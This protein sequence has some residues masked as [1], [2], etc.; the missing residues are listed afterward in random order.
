MPPAVAVWA[1]T[2]TVILG[3]PGRAALI[4]VCLAAVMVLLREPGQ[5]LLVGGLGACA[6]VITWLRCEAAEAARASGL[7]TGTIEG[8][9]RG[10]PRD[11]GDGTWLVQLS[12]EGY[13]VALPVFAG[14]EAEEITAGTLVEVT[15]RAAEATRP[16]VGTVTLSGEVTPLA[17]PRGFAAFAADV[18]E[19]FGTAVEWA[20]GDHAQGLIP[21]MVLGDVSLQTDAEQLA[22]VNTGLSHLSAVSGA[23]CM[24]VAAAALVAARLCRAGLRVQLLAAA[25]ALLVYAGLVGPEPS[26]LRASVTGMVGCVAII[27]STRAEPIHALCLSV[28]GLVFVDSDLAVNYG[29]ALSVAA[30][31]GIVAISPLFY[32]ALA[33]TGWP[34]IFLRALSVALAADLA[35]APIIAGMVGQVSLVAVVANV[36]VSPVTGAVTVLGMLAAIAAQFSPYAAAPLLWIIQPM[37]GWVRTVAE[38]GAGLPGST[39]AAT[40]AVVAVCY[41]WILAGFV[42]KRP[43]LTLACTTTLMLVLVTGVSGLPGGEGGGKVDVDTLTAH[44]VNDEEDVE[45][46]PAGTGIVVVL[47]GGEPHTR[48]V[49]TRDGVPVLYP[50]RDG[51]VDLYSDGRQV[52]RDGHF[53]HTP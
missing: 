38:A 12:V 36:V 45:P 9:V 43:R 11:I 48:P 22:Y 17:P 1:A 4:V 3:G 33:P 49:V 40:P 31:V 24:Y 29:F 14:D 8:I 32:R 21:G 25:G 18:R 13:P 27:S 47:E 15:G 20:V 53:G 51:P 7:V 26:V 2:L 37:A 34:D 44:V 30:T 35:T 50:A 42:A 16:G 28:I 23:N 41:G 39:I 5:A 10:T 6:G 52:S 19:R 46:I